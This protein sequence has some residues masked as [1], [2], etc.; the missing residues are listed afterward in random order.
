MNK[1]YIVEKIESYNV[2]INALISHE[3]ADPCEDGL[4]IKLRGLLAKKLQNEIEKW[5]DQY[6]LPPED[7]ENQAMNFNE[8]N[9]L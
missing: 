4:D 5:C 8:R 7:N 2:A 9:T 3:S 1:R 6:G